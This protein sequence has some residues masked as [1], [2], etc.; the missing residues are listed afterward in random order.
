MVSSATPT[1]MSTEVP[2][3]GN[4]LMRPD[5]EHDDGISAMVAR[6]IEPGSVMRTRMSFR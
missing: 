2:P 6:K 4:W 3:K 5:R 1:A